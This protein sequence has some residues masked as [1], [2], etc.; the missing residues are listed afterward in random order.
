MVDNII[1]TSAD[2]FSIG[3][4]NYGTSLI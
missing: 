3:V 2:P 4:N 1:D